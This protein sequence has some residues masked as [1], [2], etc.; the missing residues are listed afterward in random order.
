M[1]EE[2]K[3]Y[4]YSCLKGIEYLQNKANDNDIIVFLDG[5]Y[6]DYPEEILILIQPIIQSNCDLVIGSRVLGRREPGSLLFQQRAGNWLATKLIKL[7]YK[8][9]D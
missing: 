7:F 1:R 5:D 3:G 8:T 2:R 6:S 4:G 9:F